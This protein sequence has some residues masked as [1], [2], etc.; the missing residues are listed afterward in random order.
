MHR[1]GKTV[2]CS[3]GLCTV[4]RRLGLPAKAVIP[5]LLSSP[6]SIWEDEG[7]V[8]TQKLCLLLSFPEDGGGLTKHVHLAMAYAI[9]ECC[10]KLW[11]IWKRK[12]QR[13]SSR[14][15]GPWFGLN[16][17]AATCRY[18]GNLGPACR[19]APLLFPILIPDCNQQDV[20][21][22]SLWRAATSVIA[23]V[24]RSYTTFSFPPQNVPVCRRLVLATG[25][26]P[27]QD[28]GREILCMA[29]ITYIWTGCILA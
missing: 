4:R 22:V 19:R 11:N 12:V 23:V 15:W 26:N 13:R 9:T 1:P 25:F 5:L 16:T 18:W 8:P 28:F 6:G 27:T 2:L 14:A 20:L 10:G 29:G 3:P 17:Q 7:V 21:T 24:F